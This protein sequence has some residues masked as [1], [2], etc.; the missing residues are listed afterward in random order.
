MSGAAPGDHAQP[1]AAGVDGVVM[2]K[3]T[4]RWR[5]PSWR[6]SRRMGHRSRALG[7]RERHHSFKG[8]KPGE[9]KLILGNVE[10]APTWTRTSSAVDSKAKTVKAGCSGHEACN[11]GR[12]VERWTSGRPPTFGTA[13]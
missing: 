2:D 12:P 6:L 11:E 3:D 4:S 8:L 7:R 9:Y 5:A 10:P 1:T 13:S